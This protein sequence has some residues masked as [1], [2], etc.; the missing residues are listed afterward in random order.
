MN[1]KNSVWQSVTTNTQLSGAVHFNLKY[2]HNTLI[3]VWL[4]LCGLISS[5]F[6][7]MLLR[8]Q[9]ALKQKCNDE[10]G[11][12]IYYPVHVKNEQDPHF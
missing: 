10:N 8:T 2:F 3:F 4:L 11:N 12:V 7:E 5:V 6:K 1:C 9:E